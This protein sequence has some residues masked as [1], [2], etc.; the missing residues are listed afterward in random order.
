MVQFGDEGKLEGPC[1]ICGSEFY[2]GTTRAAGQRILLFDSKLNGL[3]GTYIC[4]DCVYNL[5]H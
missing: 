5:L 2:A 4:S 3:G 1:K